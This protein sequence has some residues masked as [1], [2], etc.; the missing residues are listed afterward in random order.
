MS[1][2][3]DTCIHAGIYI[4]AIKTLKIRLKDRH[5][6]KLTQMSRSVN[7]VWNYI[8]DLSF[9]SIRERN[10][11]MSGYDLQPYTK[12]TSADLGLSANTI[13][14]IGHEYVTRRKQFKKAKLKFRSSYGNGRALGWIPFQIGSI[15]VN[16]DSIQY[17]KKTFKFLDKSYDLSSYKVKSGTFSE[18][19]HGRWYVNLAVEY[20]PA[21]I[22]NTS[23]TSVGIDLGCKDAVT[24]SNG[25]KLEG[26]WYR[27]L[28]EELATA[29]RTKQWKKA[30]KIN[31]KIKNKRKNDLHLFSKNIVSNNA[32][33]FV[34]NVSSGKLIKTKMAKSVNDSAW[35]QFKTMLKYKSEASGG[36]Y[37]EVNEAYSTQTCSNCGEIP[38]SSPKGRAGLGMRE[39]TCSNCGAHHDRDINA[40]INIKNIGIKSISGATNRPLVEEIVLVEN[41]STEKSPKI[42]TLF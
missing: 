13:Q 30:K 36:I 20:T 21:K 34:G 25:S 22:K 3:G 2:I 33:V 23:Y 19:N 18:D 26:G 4:M 38:D 5:A 15:K 11:W 35:Y 39:W 6:S 29:Q 10:I 16:S 7:Y 40:A 27:K 1:W 42:N 17:Y 31:R 24:C 14:M 28:E 37:E 8:N 41:T 9:R 32:C 12:G